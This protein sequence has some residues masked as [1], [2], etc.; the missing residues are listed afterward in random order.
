[1]PESDTRPALQRG[2]ADEAGLDEARLQVARHLLA[3]WAQD[4]SVPGSAI[5]VARH[6]VLLESRAFG[7]AAHG[8]QQRQMA[9]D[10]LFLV[11]SVTK[12]VTA[13]AVLQLVERG[14]L[15]LADPVY[16]HIP[17]FTG[18]IQGLDRDRIRVEHLLTHTSG[19]PD[20]LPQNEALRARHAPLADFVKDVCQCEL[21]FAAGT[22][23]SYQSMGTLLAGEIVER[24]TGQSLRQMM[25]ERIFAP[26]AM[27]STSL[28]IRDELAS[29]AADVVLPQ[30]Q[31]GTDYHWNTSYWQRLGAPWGGMFSTVDD[32]AR[33]LVAT[34]GGGV[35]Q[36]G[37]ILGTLA[38]RAMI[39]DRTTRM[40]GLASE[41]RSQRW[42][43][44]W[45]LGAWGDLASAASFS[46]G[47]AT[48]TLVGADPES[49]LACVI[50]TTRPGA[51]VHR[52]ATAVQAAVI[53]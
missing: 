6:G 36:D 45:R 4:G 31:T 30:E 39:S 43:L 9:P 28:G 33:L 14:L 8:N 52:V 1:M 21:L 44:G 11:A 42:G 10:N 32:L 37:R 35:L 5:A 22:Q 48:G 46:H 2:T 13:I 26:L 47:G 25:A 29:R 23:I 24:I 3:Q 50:F 34:L 41:H 17:E 18:V 16:A 40:P 19:L 15:S 51:P 53:N 27:A 49:G 7:V 20:M 38:N 12:P